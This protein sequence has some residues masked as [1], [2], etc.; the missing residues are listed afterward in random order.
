VRLKFAERFGPAREIHAGSGYW[1]QDSATLVLAAPIAPAALQIRW[2][3]GQL[4]DWPWPAGVK[5]IQVSTTGI[6]PR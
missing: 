6:K 3:D 5:S 4:Q 1:S 2:P